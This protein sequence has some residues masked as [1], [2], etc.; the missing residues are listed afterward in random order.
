MPLQPF[1]L[2]EQIRAVSLGLL[3]E[4]AKAD[5]QCG[6]RLAD[7]VVQ[8]ARD[9]AALCLLHAQHALR[10]DTEPPFGFRHALQ[11]PPVLDRNALDLRG[12][13]VRTD[14]RGVGS[15]RVFV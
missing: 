8:V 7:A 1:H 5:P 2:R 4:D 6:E 10:D 3:R 9:P 14:S 13:R 11:Q 12:N 15:A